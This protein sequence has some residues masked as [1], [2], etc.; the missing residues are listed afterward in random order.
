MAIG[1]KFQ[2]SAETLE[3]QSKWW[4]AP[5]LPLDVDYPCASDGEPLL[6]IC[7]IRLEDI[8]QYDTENQLPHKGMLYFFA[9]MAE[10][11]APLEGISGEEHNGLGEWSES[12][13][14]VIYSPTCENLET[15]AI[16]DD[17]DEPA[18]L[19]AEKIEFSAV[20]GGYDSFKLLGRPY[21]DE[22]AEQYPDDVCLLQIDESDEWGLRLYDCGMI[23]FLISKQALAEQ[24]WDEVKVYFHSF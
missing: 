23:C 1:L 4:G 21:Y 14:K 15:F 2:S 24:R 11:V 5:D 18:F 20:E 6:F 19:E 16:V 7:Q 10:Y 3:A 9:D 13:F 12:C 22:I 8:A 17:D